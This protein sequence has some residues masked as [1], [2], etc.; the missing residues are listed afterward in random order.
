MWLYSNINLSEHPKRINENPHVLVY[1]TCQKY[2]ETNKDSE[3]YVKNM[4]GYLV[5]DFG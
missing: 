3:G 1:R 2:T 4:N 5:L